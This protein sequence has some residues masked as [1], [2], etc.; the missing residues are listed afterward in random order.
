M[1]KITSLILKSTLLLLSLYFTLHTFPSNMEKNRLATM[2]ELGERNDV[3]GF[4]EILDNWPH[5]NTN[6]NTTTTTTTNRNHQPNIKC[7]SHRVITQDGYI[8]QLKRI[9]IPNITTRG[10]VILL[11]GLGDSS[12]TFI[13][14]GFNSSLAGILLQNQWETWLMDERGKAPFSH[15]NKS[16]NHHSVD[17][18]EFSLQE[19]I[20]YDIPSTIR[21][22]LKISGKQHVDGF[23]AHS[24]GGLL[25]FLSLSEYPDLANRVKTVIAMASPLHGWS[26]K[27]A[28]PRFLLQGFEFIV[29]RL[30]HDPARLA[31]WA[32]HFIS[33]TCF[34][35]PWAC[36]IGVCLAAGGCTSSNPNHRLDINSDRFS[37]IFTFYPVATSLRNIHH[38]TQFEEKQFMTR[39]DFLNKEL[40]QEKYDG[41]S[42]PPQFSFKK[43]RTPAYIYFGSHDMFVG[44]TRFNNVDELFSHGILQEKRLYE[45][46]GHAHF[47]WHTNAK[48]NIYK[49][50][51]DVLGNSNTNNQNFHRS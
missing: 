14:S 4:I 38:L 25:A 13:N 33:R 42:E 16:K 45:G 51:V 8:L 44:A 10:V 27:R 24:Q 12:A 20:D 46:F 21:Y 30:F 11:P 47:V 22:V 15:V 31:S 18:W 48:D 19:N 37:S 50:I 39:F 34:F 6:T 2:L 32:R 23:I 43:L 26:S 28:I 3:C 41:Q 29:Y 49:S 5:T 35:I 17:F 9:Y 36:T 40:N 1:T 7:E